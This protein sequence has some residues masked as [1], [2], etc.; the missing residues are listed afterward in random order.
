MKRVTR[1]GGTMLLAGATAIGLAACASTGGAA[2]KEDWSTLTIAA[3]TEP[4]SFDPAQAAEANFAQYFQPVF[5]TLIRRMPDGELAPMLATAWSLSDDGLTATLDLRD[6]VTFS[7]GEEFT[8]EVAELNLERFRDSGGPFSA[9]LANMTD[10]VVVDD[11]TIELQFSEP[12]PDIFQYLGNSAGYMASPAQ[13][14][15]DAVDT[16]PIGSGPY[17]LIRSETVAGDRYSYVKR[18]DYWDE[19]AEWDWFENLVIRPMNDSSARM[20]AM[21]SGEV[22]T[23]I[24]EPKQIPEAEKSGLNVTTFQVNWYG[25]SIFDRAGEIVPALADARVRQAMN[26]AIN[27]EAILKAV[28]LGYGEPTDQTFNVDS[29]AYEP[30][31][32]DYYSYDPDRAG[33][34]LAEAGYEDGFSITMPS[35]SSMD[36]AML[37]AVGQNLGAV[38]IDVTF[39]EVAPADFIP[40]LRQGKFAV[41][42]MSFAQPPTAWGTISRFLLPGS[43]WNV[44]KTQDDRVDAASD[45]ALENLTDPDAYEEAVQQINAVAVEDAWNVV[46]YRVQQGVVSRNGLTAVGQA[47]QAAPSIY[48]YTLDE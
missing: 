22:D 39:Q 21:K 5:D 48:N 28:D 3:V 41:T 25:L 11:D 43:A 23:G 38:G 35:S 45:A 20:N 12:D 34:L 17:E 9:N 30:E 37:A 1:T 4:T 26:Y 29:E 44:Y 31:Y 42:W 18:D 6:D 19:D 10:A 40:S 2:P 8:P 7:D 47:G 36:P 13:F 27:G 24:I 16:V 14:D 32:D 15:S 46:F 33:E